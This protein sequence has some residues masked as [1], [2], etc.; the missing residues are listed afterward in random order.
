ML[1]VAVHLDRHIVPAA[2]GIAV[3]ALHG[4]ADPQVDRQIQEGIPV[5]LQQRRAA[6]GGTVIDDEKIHVRAG[7]FQAFHG[8]YNVLFL[9]VAGDQHQNFS[10][11]RGTSHP[12]GHSPC[13]I[14]VSKRRSSSARR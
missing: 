11:Q 1:A 3:A 10:V 2:F 13:K 4:A 6:V 12:G 7:R 8:V 14:N 5:A 9:I